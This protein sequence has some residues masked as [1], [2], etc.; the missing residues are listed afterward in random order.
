MNRMN[1]ASAVFALATGAMTSG[2]SASF[3]SSGD[4]SD[5]AVRVGHIDANPANPQTGSGIDDPAFW[6]L[7]TFT[8]SVTSDVSIDV[9]RLVPELDPAAAVYRGDASG[10]DFDAFPEFGEDGALSTFEG[11]FADD[12]DPNPFGTTD[13]DG[14]PLF[15]RDPRIEFR[16]DVGDTPEVFSVFVANF[17]G[18]FL[19]GGY[20]FEI[21]VEQ[22]E[23]VPTGGS[24]SLLLVA[25]AFVFGRRRGLS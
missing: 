21:A 18:G 17:A 24:V 8:V 9:T 13:E 2:A 3:V 12:T 7:W 23:V 10:L 1:C 14:N 5:G 20:D 11:G 22:T 25:G 6:A 16:A 15:F 19:P 4:L